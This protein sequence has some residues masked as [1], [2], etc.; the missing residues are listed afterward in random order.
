MEKKNTRVIFYKLEFIGS[1]R[2][3]AS[4]LSSLNNNLAEAIHKIKVLS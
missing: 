3:M 1:P 2:F 4:S